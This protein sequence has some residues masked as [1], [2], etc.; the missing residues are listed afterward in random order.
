[1]S[2]SDFLEDSVLL[3]QFQRTEKNP[4]DYSRS[5]SGYYSLDSNNSLQRSEGFLSPPQYDPEPHS[6][7]RPCNLDLSVLRR[8][9]PPS[10]E[11]RR[12]LT[13]VLED[14]ASS[15]SDDRYMSAP[16]ISSPTTAP[17]SPRVRRVKRD[18]SIL[19]ERPLSWTS[20]SIKGNIQSLAVSVFKL[21]TEPISFDESN[22]CDTGNFL[23]EFEGKYCSNFT[24]YP[25]V[26]QIE[27][28]DR[29]IFSK[30]QNKVQ[31]ERLLL[32]VASNSK[33][34]SLEPVINFLKP[35]CLITGRI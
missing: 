28:P 7:T 10:K 19:R 24:N 14:I 15:P 25:G 18:K 12:S 4:V 35:D 23:F 9:E 29:S 1:M 26:A 22:Q 33:L 34:R 5:E 32:S 20:R 8:P 2:E 16:D 27:K 11:N 30:K 17:Q 21:S 3:E 31:V 6:P 13:C